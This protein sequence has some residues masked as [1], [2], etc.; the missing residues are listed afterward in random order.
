MT[1]QNH[2]PSIQRNVR[3]GDSLL[4][5]LSLRTKKGLSSLNTLDKNDGIKL[6]PFGFWARIFQGP[7]TRCH[8]NGIKN[9]QN[10]PN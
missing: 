7:D 9:K 8:S 3:S 1:W 4:S 2:Y 5:P 6:F 10:E